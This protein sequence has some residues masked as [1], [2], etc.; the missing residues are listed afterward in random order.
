MLCSSS[1]P[2]YISL[3][4]LDTPFVLVGLPED[5]LSVKPFTLTGS[6]IHITGSNIGSSTEIKEMLEFA[7]KH[8]V[9]PWIE[10][11]PMSQVNEG[12]KKVQDNDVKFRVVLEQGK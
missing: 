7:S 11:M 9:R 5:Q 12:I 3:C 8:D 10:L 1:S 6:R 4:K 2:R